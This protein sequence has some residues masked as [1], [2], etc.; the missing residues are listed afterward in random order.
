ML[1]SNTYNQHFAPLSAEQ[2]AENATKKVIC[3][4]SGGVDSSVSAFILQQQ[5]YQVEGLFMKN[6]EEDDVITDYISNPVLNL[7]AELGSGN[8]TE[9]LCQNLHLKI[10]SAKQNIENEVEDYS[11]QRREIGPGY[12]VQ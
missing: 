9:E 1:T 10:E 11:E 5:G 8:V 12:F 2:L 4:M 3:G 7:I 6:W